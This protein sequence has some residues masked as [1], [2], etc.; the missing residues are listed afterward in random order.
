M[1]AAAAQEELPPDA[2]EPEPLWKTRKPAGR[3]RRRRGP[4][5]AGRNCRQ[6]GDAGRSGA[7]P[8]EATQ[9]YAQGEQALRQQD[10]QTALDLFRRAYQL[11]DQLD[12]ATAQ[13]LQ[14]HLQLLSAP[15][16]SFAR[17]E[18]R[19]AAGCTRFGAGRARAAGFERS[20]E[21]GN[22]RRQGPRERAQAGDGDSE[23]SP[24]RGRSR[25]TRTPNSRAFSL[26]ASIARSPSST[27]TS[28]SIGPRSSSMNRTR[29]F[30]PK[31]I[32]ALKT[33]LVIDDKLAQLV[34][35]CNQA[36]GRSSALPRPKCWPSGPASSTP[37][38]RWSSSSSGTRSS[39]SAT[40]RNQD[41][42]D[43]QGRGLLVA[44]DQRRKHA[45]IPFDDND[46]YRFGDATKWKELTKSRQR[47]D[48]RV[49]DRAAA[50]ANWRSSRSSRR[51]SR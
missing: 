21:E 8:S 15:P 39:S 37:T 49:E 9:L 43:G 33:R 25:G 6:S 3:A 16:A 47:A 19:D 44:D 28:S 4:A 18:A 10:T 48:G 2:I 46:P 32:A 36:D 20:G 17:R 11:R 41:I 23:R 22:G 34:D 27:N 45:A 42:K 13:R 31:S 35:D 26:A 40:Q 14:D 51:R 30:W 29:P 38:T 50:N 1:Q 24:D 5:V 12:P 7:V